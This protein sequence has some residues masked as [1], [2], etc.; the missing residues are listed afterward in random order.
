MLMLCSRE[1]L[2]RGGYWQGPSHRQY[3][4]NRAQ[5]AL[6]LGSHSESA[7][8]SGCQRESGEKEAETW[9]CCEATKGP[10]SLKVFIT[11]A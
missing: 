9:V 2:D 8:D 3:L 6:A 1:V 10:S 4:V 11:V 7:S 5:G